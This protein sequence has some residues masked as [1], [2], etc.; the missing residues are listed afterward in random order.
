MKFKNYSRHQHKKQE[1][2]ETL[3][4][5]IDYMQYTEQRGKELMQGCTTTTGFVTTRY[6][7]MQHSRILIN[8][9][10]RQIVVMSR[11]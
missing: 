5:A 7:T 1:H 2:I 8:D 3:N 6:Y 4:A 11:K 10:L 9:L